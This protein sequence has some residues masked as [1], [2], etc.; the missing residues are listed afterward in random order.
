MTLNLKLQLFSSSN[1]CILVM[2][3]PKK[4]LY[5]TIN[6]QITL[7]IKIISW[8]LTFE[9]VTWKSIKNIHYLGAINNCIFLP[10]PL[11]ALTTWPKDQYGSYT[12]QGQFIY[13]PGFGNYQ[14]KGSKESGQITLGLYQQTDCLTNQQL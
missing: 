8:T 11:S 10:W 7:G 12:L 14:A 6:M 2:R 9:H 13:V 4:S 3:Y 1:H 5:H